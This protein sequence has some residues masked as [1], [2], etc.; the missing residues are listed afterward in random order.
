MLINSC[1]EERAARRYFFWIFYTF[2]SDFTVP[3]YLIISHLDVQWN[4]GYLP[5]HK[6]SQILCPASSTTPPPST[7]SPNENKNTET[8]KII[9]FQE[10]R[11]GTQICFKMSS[12]NW[13]TA[14]LKFSWEGQPIYRSTLLPKWARP[15]LH[16]DIKSN[17]RTACH[18]RSEIQSWGWE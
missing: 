10:E 18:S 6:K 13:T 11:E 1:H 4:L 12:S 16:Q 15:F 3:P 5:Q 8:N 2:F 9:F 14:M 17:S 7:K